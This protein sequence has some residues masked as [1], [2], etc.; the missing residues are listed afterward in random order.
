MRP[1]IEFLLIGLL[2]TT[3]SVAKEVD[4]AT[5]PDITRYCTTELGAD[6]GLDYPQIVDLNRRGQA[7][8]WGYLGEGVEVFLWDRKR[9]YKLIDELAHE[10]E[11][12]A[13]AASGFND[14]G[15]IVGTQS[16]KPDGAFLRAVIWKRGK[17]L[18]FLEPAP[19]DESSIAVDINNRGEVVG[20]SG[21]YPDESATG[22]RSV[23]WD[24]HSRVTVIPEFPDST[25]GRP[26]AMNDA[27]QVIGANNTPSDVRGYIWDRKS[28]LRAIEGLMGD[29]SSS[30]SAINDHGDVV[31]TSS[32]YSGQHAIFWSE[33]TG[34][35]DLGDLPGGAELSHAYDINNHRQI[36]GNATGQSGGEA[37]IWD[38][39]GQIHNLNELLV[40][41]E[42][43]DY[44]LHMLYGRTI[45]DAGWITAFGFDTRDRR[46]RT[47]L[48]TPARRSSTNSYQFSCGK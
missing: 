14:R 29:D 17:G 4:R 48:L 43:D 39:E 27:G 45:T 18:K 5:P 35:V 9:G 11:I 42:P 46:Y 47:F 1:V 30:P 36:V 7:L 23:I 2:I 33:E 22:E 15:Q 6:S 40:R 8:G 16:I 31:G 41:D 13:R 10:Q 3:S 24:R 26:Y 20:V 44:Y 37:V 21:P 38:S 25:G 32:F 12:P 19:G 28:G 34:V